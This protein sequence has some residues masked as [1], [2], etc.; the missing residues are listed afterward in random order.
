MDIAKYMMADGRLSNHKRI[1]L[2]VVLN[3]TRE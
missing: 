1:N 3:T 2:Y